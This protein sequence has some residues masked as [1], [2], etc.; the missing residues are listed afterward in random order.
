MMNWRCGVG[1]ALEGFNDDWYPIYEREG[2][3]RETAFGFISSAAGDT[4]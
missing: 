1:E 2:C 4:I 3:G